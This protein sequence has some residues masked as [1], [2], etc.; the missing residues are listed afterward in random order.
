MLNEEQLRFLGNY[1]KL[2]LAS[3]TSLKKDQRKSWADRAKWN[4]EFK[5][6]LEQTDIDFI[7]NIVNGD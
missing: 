2:G 3:S 6:V 7:F 4:K 1:I 5:G